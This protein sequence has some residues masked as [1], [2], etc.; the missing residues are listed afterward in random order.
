[1]P[2]RAITQQVR[3]QPHCSNN[4]LNIKKN[5]TN[6]NACWSMFFNLN[7]SQ[8]Y[9]NL[10]ECF[11]II[12]C[13]SMLF[14]CIWCRCVQSHREYDFHHIVQIVYLISKNTEK[15]N[16]CPSMLFNL[17]TKHN[18]TSICSNVFEVFCVFWMLFRC[19]WCRC[20]QSHS[21]YESNHIIHIVYLI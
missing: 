18:A 3:V 21:G 14:R 12:L 1:M 10:F 17:S 4:L 9:H 13:F 11:W 7:R 8:G 6:K 19:I 16:A 20:V 2:L 15:E 5:R